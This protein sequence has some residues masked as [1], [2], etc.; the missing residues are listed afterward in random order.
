MK[1]IS[2]TQLRK[3]ELKD[4]REGECLKV[5]FQ[6]G[7]AFYVIVK[8]EQVMKDKVEAICQMIDGSRGF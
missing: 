6:K 8:P 2:W 5:R 7:V 4:I 1:E 3:L